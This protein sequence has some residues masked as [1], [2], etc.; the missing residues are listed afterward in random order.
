MALVGIDQRFV[1]Y[2]LWRN[3]AVHRPRVSWRRQTSKPLQN[4]VVRGVVDVA[5]TTKLLGLMITWEVI[6][7]ELE[8]F[9]QKRRASI[10]Y[11]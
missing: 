4:T 7:H 11:G 10:P 1:E 6:E 5:G 3:R 8:I 2:A 9:R